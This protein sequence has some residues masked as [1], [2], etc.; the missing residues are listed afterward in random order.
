MKGLNLSLKD[1][2]ALLVRRKWW[3]IF[4]FL[5]LSSA[6]VLLTYLL[7]KLYV[8]ETLILIRPRDVPADFVKDLIAGT[9]EQRLSSIEQTVLSRTNL[10]QILHEFEDKLPEYKNLNM[11][12]QVLKLNGQIS[13][14]FEA[15]RRGNVQLPLT[16]FRISYQNRNPA[17]AQKIAAKLTSLFIE[18]DGR[19]RETQVFGTTEFLTGELSKIADQLEQSD[20]KLKE[21]K[22]RRRYELPNQLETNLRT[23]DRLG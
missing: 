12:Q 9:T 1:S 7:P 3:V 22:A 20:E 5:A 18:Q 15:E 14:K 4:P 10:V 16:Y 13:V 19:A 8:S 21:L 17:L 6:A 23:L 2:L 11:D